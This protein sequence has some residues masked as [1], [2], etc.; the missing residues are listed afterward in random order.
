MNKHIKEYLNFYIKQEHLTHAVFIKGKWGS[1][2]TFFIKNI[3]EEWIKDNVE[4][5]NLITLK[6]IYIS[7][8]GISNKSEIIDKI[9]EQ[10]YPLLYSK[11]AKLVGSIL[12]GVVKSTFKIDL[13]DDGNTD[14]TINLDFNP[15]S[16]F[17]EASDNIKGDKIIIFDDLER[18]KIS[19]EEL[20]GYVNDFLEH[21]MCKI[22]LIGDEEKILQKED[23][24]YS[25]IKEKIIGQEFEFIPEEIVALKSFISDF[26]NERKFF[27]ILSNNEDIIIKIFQTSENKNLRLFKRS[28]LELKR[29]IEALDDDLK[30]NSNYKEFIR[31]LVSHFIIFYTEFKSNNQDIILFQ[32]LFVE[33]KD[34]KLK[35]FERLIRSEK[36]TD[37]SRLFESKNLIEFIDKGTSNVLIKELNHCKALFP[38]TEKDWEKLY[39]Y[40]FLEDSEFYDLVTIIEDQYF[41]TNDFN[42]FEILHITGLFLFFNDENLYNNK[43]ISDIVTRAKELLNNSNDINNFTSSDISDVSYGKK[44][45][46]F[47]KDNFKEVINYCKEIIE[48]NLKE[49]S[50]NNIRNFFNNLNDDNIESLYGKLEEIDP[51]T[52]NENINTPFLRNVDIINLV[53]ILASLNNKS[54]HTFNFF[55]RYRYNINNNKNRNLNNLIKEELNFVN[56]LIIEIE[57]LDLNDKPIKKKLFKDLL[58]DLNNIKLK[59]EN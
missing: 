2:K 41:N 22:I 12:K 20:F 11:G 39:L 28:F 57:K 59:L 38:E 53:N 4:I 42:L 3:I 56:Q 25:K 30:S 23:V 37:S 32:R 48:N 14:T 35:D 9:K 44:I 27:N 26:K 24:N 6:P 55:I 21:S 51:F 15:I 5:D 49:K 43:S 8:N 52:R 7:L 18:C 36:I 47:E 19:L 17:K 58:I 1:G 46:Y 10:L 40:I 13:N 50:E 54:L 29:L 31:S 33:N 16:L 34:V 45:T